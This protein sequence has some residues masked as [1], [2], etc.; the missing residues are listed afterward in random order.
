MSN[1]AVSTRRNVNAN[2][3]RYEFA[4]NAALALLGVTKRVVDD[5]AL[6]GC[7]WRFLAPCARTNA[8]FAF[9]A[10][11][12]SRDA[13]SDFGEKNVMHRA[14]KECFTLTSNGASCAR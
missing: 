7:P 6:A 1:W 14:T 11:F 8:A 13:L 10:V 3:M 4:D 2:D 9:A 12:F 5:A